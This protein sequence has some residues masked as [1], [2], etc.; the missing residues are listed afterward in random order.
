MNSS[1]TYS[2][3]IFNSPPNIPH[4]PTPPDNATSVAIEPILSWIGGDPDPTDTVTYDVYFGNTTPPQHVSINQTQQT[5]TPGTLEYAT[6]YYWKII[7]WDNHEASSSGPTWQFTTMSMNYPPYPPSNPN[8]GNET[9]NISINADLSWIGGDPNAEDTVTYDIFFGATSPPPKIVN[10]QTDITYNP[11]TMDY[12][13]T[14]YWKIVSWDNHGAS[15]SGP[16]WEF[17]TITIPNQPPNKPDK[18]AGETN[19]KIN[20][21]YTYTTKTIDLDGDQV[22]Y[23]WDWGDGNSGLWDGPYTS[24]TTAS[25][26]H[27]W[28]TKGTYSIKVKAKD[29]SGNE[30][31][32]SDPLAVSMPM[33]NPQSQNPIIINQLLQKIYILI[34]Q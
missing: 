4:T 8:P 16:T 6:T 20:I 23:W 22:W 10:N 31:A 17:T 27:T 34:N 15:S 1:T 2:F 3:I 5:Y 14:Y 11:G 25:N 32:W 26:T 18:P 9:T 13:T 12:N 19:G 28:T 29:I 30:S 21:P 7:A 24:N 33:S